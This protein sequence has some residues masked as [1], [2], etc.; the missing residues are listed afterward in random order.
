MYRLV[1]SDL[2]GTLLNGNKQI[3]KRTI[4][5]VNQLT[6]KGILFVPATGR[7]DVMTKPFKV[8]AECEFGHRM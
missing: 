4:Q 1:L 3:S 6:K 8:H 5:T 7:L 2:D